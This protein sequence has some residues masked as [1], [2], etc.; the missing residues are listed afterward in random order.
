MLTPIAEDDEWRGKA[1][2]RDYPVAGVEVVVTAAYTRVDDR[3][4]S[5]IQ[6]LD[7]RVSATGK[8]VLS[9]DGKTLTAL[10]T[11]PNAQGQDVTTTTVYDR[12][13]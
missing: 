5:V 11:S 7:G 13:Q 4:F 6:K 3:T 9:P 2:G 1:D 12:Q 8:L 10:T